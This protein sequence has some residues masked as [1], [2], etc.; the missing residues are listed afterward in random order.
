MF[1][2]WRLTVVTGVRVGVEQPGSSSHGDTARKG[3]VFEVINDGDSIYSILHK[4]SKNSNS[5]KFCV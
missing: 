3:S 4:P 2:T 5:L 1:S